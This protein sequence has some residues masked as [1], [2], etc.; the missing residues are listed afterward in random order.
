[1]LSSSPNSQALA[2]PNGRFGGPLSAS[3]PSGETLKEPGRQSKPNRD[4]V[5]DAS[6]GLTWAGYPAEQT[7]RS[8]YLKYHY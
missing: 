4:R 7:E 8:I 1:M 2:I 3:S 5:S 6:M